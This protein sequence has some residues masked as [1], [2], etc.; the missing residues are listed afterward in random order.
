MK[1]K[2]MLVYT[3]MGL[4]IR[5]QGLPTKAMNN[6]DSTEIFLCMY[7]ISRITFIYHNVI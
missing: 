6:D 5:R 1:I 7:Q 4:Q 3:V 2:Q